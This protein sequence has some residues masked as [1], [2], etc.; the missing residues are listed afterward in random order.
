MKADIDYGMGKC[1][2]YLIGNLENCFAKLW[3]LYQRLI[4]ELTN[5]MGRCHHLKEELQSNKM[6][7][8]VTNR[9]IIECLGQSEVTILRS[10]Q[11]WEHQENNSRP[12]MTT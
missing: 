8:M 10:C 5:C 1:C 3:G 11:E 2:D 9:K 12:K 6:K 4:D 7:K